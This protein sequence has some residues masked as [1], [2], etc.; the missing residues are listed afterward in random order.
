MAR[1]YLVAW[2]AGFFDGEGCVYIGRQEQKA[3]PQTHYQLTATVF[4]NVREPLDIMQGLF[5]GN[6]FRRDKGWVWQM[7]GHPL[8]PTLSEMIPY[9]VVK[10]AQSEL[11]VAFQLRKTKRGGKYTNPSAARL[12]D[13][14]DYF[15][16]RNMK[17][18]PAEQRVA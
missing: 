4:Q 3:K 13:E 14:Q 7:S 5:G 6:V 12:L 2:A 9:M 16:M 10:K 1:Q 15:T 8:V 18:Q 17:I 11:A